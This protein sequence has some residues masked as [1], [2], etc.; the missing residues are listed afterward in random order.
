VR[1]IFI[2]SGRQDSVPPAHP[3]LA[4]NLT[5]T[6][7]LFCREDRILCHWHIRL[8]RRTSPRLLFIL[9][10][11]QDSV[12]PAHP[13]LAEN[14]TATS[15]LF[16]R[17]DKI[18][19]HWHIRLWRRTSPRLLFILSGRQDSNLRL[20]APKASALAGLSYFPIFFS[21]IPACF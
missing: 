10:G 18:L 12:P 19:C 15:F 9:S 6:S 1:R 13:P 2:L 14:L 20:L 3:P 5:A 21:V 4:E 7:Y 17:E 16:C 8:W 11:R